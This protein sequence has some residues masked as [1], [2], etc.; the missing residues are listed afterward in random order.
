MEVGFQ[1]SFLSGGIS[2]KAPF[3]EKLSAQ[4]VLGF[5]GSLTSYSARGIYQFSQYSNTDV[6][7]FGSAGLWT[8]NGGRGIGTE[9]VFGLGVGVGI[10]YNLQQAFPDLPPLNLSAEIGS[11]FA[12]FDTFAGF[13]VLSLGFGLHYQF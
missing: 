5:A 1:N 7:A 12:S 8:F 10:D 13:N 2:V 4:G 9:S 11:S 3:G 6:Y